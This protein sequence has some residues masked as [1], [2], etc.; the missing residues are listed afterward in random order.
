[1]PI[2]SKYAVVLL[3]QLALG[4]KPQGDYPEELLNPLVKKALIKYSYLDDSFLDKLAAKGI[5]VKTDLPFAADWL[6]IVEDIRK[7]NDHSAKWIATL[8]YS[9]WGFMYWFAQVTGIGLLK[10]IYEQDNETTLFKKELLEKGFGEVKVTHGTSPVYLMGKWWVDDLVLKM[11][12]LWD[13]LPYAIAET[14]LPKLELKGG[15]HMAR[16]NELLK[17]KGQLGISPEFENMFCKLIEEMKD[18]EYVK[19]HRDTEAHRHVKSYAEVFGLVEIHDSLA[20]VSRRLLEDELHRCREALLTTVGL[21]LFRNYKTVEPTKFK[22]PHLFHGVFVHW[23]GRAL[24][25]NEMLSITT[26]TQ[27]NY[28]MLNRCVVQEEGSSE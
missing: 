22:A 4:F 18:I 12:A 3:I 15:K 24:Q 17:T 10:E 13:K 25:L 26:S 6:T 23:R 21:I 2:D 8:L 5:P 28:G 11:R 27:R 16:I 14:S 1:M 7:L 20:T 19:K 9:E